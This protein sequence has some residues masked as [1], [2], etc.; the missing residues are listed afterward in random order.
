MVLLY[1]QALGYQWV[2]NRQKYLPLGTLHSGVQNAR[3]AVDMEIVGF[4]LLWQPLFSD[5]V[6]DMT[7]CEASSVPSHSPWDLLPGALS[8]PVAPLASVFSL[9]CTPS[10][11]FL[12]NASAKH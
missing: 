5:L 11:H 9:L 4:L 2:Q 8:P 12:A 1:P 6:P 3:Y 7:P 10:P